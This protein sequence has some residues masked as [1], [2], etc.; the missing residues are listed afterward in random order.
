[1]IATVTITIHV[2]N[3]WMSSLTEESVFRLVS[4]CPLLQRV[5]YP[6][7]P[8]PD[9]RTPHLSIFAIVLIQVGGVCGWAC[10]D[11]LATLDRFLQ[12][13]WFLLLVTPL[14][15]FSSINLLDPSPP[16]P[17]PGQFLPFS[18]TG[19][20]VSTISRS[21]MTTKLI[22]SYSEYWQLFKYIFKMGWHFYH[23]SFDRSSCSYG[24]PQ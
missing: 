15:S 22:E 4:A 17:P 21:S 20:A 5:L 11:L 9:H 12:F 24:T 19:W 23:F 16:I 14:G 7:N 2:L 6:S 8:N 10:A 3:E 18:S 13:H 1:M